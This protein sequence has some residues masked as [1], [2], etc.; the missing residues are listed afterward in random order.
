MNSSTLRRPLTITVLS[1][2]LYAGMSMAQDMDSLDSVSKNQ[3]QGSTASAKAPKSTQRIIVRQ[4]YDAEKRQHITV[5]DDGLTFIHEEHDPE[6]S[7]LS[8]YRDPV[9]GKVQF[10]HG[11]F[12][13]TPAW[14]AQHD[15]SFDRLK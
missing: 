14:K 7:G 12:W 13:E 6:S 2:L 5:F 1:T 9:T 15:S 11:V 3:L 4:E 10:G 8:V